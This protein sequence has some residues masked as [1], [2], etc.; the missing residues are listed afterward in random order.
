MES[1]NEKHVTIDQLM[2]L[3]ITVKFLLACGRTEQQIAEDL[4]QSHGLTPMDI[5][6]LM[7]LAA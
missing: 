2:R 7:R 5:K 6:Q 4:I 1:K 3:V